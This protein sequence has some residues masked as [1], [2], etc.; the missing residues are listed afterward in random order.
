MNG[1]SILAGLIAL[2]TFGSSTGI[3]LDTY[4][5]NENSIPMTET[6][7]EQLEAMGFDEYEIATMSQDNF[8][9]LVSYEFL[10]R[11]K[12]LSLESHL[13]WKLRYFVKS[14]QSLKFK[15][16]QEHCYGKK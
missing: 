12:R 7:Y 3:S 10:Y 2:A 1:T 4:Y 15:I 5:V 16:L 8:D 13:K 6:Q 14:A 9:K 11:M